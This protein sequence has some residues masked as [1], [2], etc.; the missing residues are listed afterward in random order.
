MLRSYAATM[1][2]RLLDQVRATIRAKHYSYRTEKTYVQWVRRFVL[3]HGK[4]HPAQ[5]G[6]DEVRD[7]L[8]HLAVKRQVAASSQNQAL[9]AILFLYRE[10]L[11]LEIG[12]IDG[13][14]RAK[15]PSRIPVVLTRAEV[16]SVFKHLRGTP[17]LAVGLLYGG[18]LRLTECLG[19]RVKDIDFE[20]GQ[21]LVRDGKG[22]KDRATILPGAVR[23]ALLAH[24]REAKRLH[25][26]DLALG[27]GRV[28]L[29][30]ALAR[31]H[32]NADR[33]WGWQFVFPASRH[34]TD[35]RTGKT[36][37]FH[38]VDS[39]VQKAVKEA[40]R[41]S[42]IA[43]PASCHTF[44]HSFATHLLEDGY[45]I[46]TVQQLL[47]HRDLRTTMIYTHVLRR[48]S[49]AVRSPLDNR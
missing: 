45:D 13:V 17:H 14:V 12:W 28:P 32:P 40:V 3:H 47:G 10:V 31:K 21:V 19:L 2:A 39:A 27:F 7:F 16:R 9:A 26:R 37:R 35:P 15:R 38:L 18:G 23:D 33:E 1:K 34:C 46:R 6:E 29:P 4:R 25:E 24:L 30:F 36:V 43:K 49:L 11:R 22:Q 8:T 48:G 5:M 41:R 44:R 42:G 20:Y